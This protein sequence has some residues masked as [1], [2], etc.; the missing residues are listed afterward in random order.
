LRVR[1]PGLP[2]LVLLILLVFSWNLANLGFSTTANASTPSY[3]SQSCLASS[4]YVYCVQ[5]ENTYYAPLSSS[6]IGPWKTS[7]S[8]PLD[9]GTCYASG[10]AVYCLDG[11]DGGVESN[12]VYYAIINS[13]GFGKWTKTTSYPVAES[14]GG[15]SCFASTAFIY[16]LGGNSTVLG[17][18]PKGSPPGTNGSALSYYAS[19]TSSGVGT[20]Q[21]TSEYPLAVLYGSGPYTTNGTG[22]ICVGSLGYAYCIAGAYCYNTIAGPGCVS[23]RYAYYAAMGNGIQSPVVNGTGCPPPGLNCPNNWAKTTNYPDLG[24]SFDNS[25]TDVA[26]LSCSTYSSYIYCVGG[27]YYDD[28]NSTYYATVSSSGIGNW[29]KTTSYPID[30][31]EATCVTYSGYIYCIDGIT[32]HETAN[33]ISPPTT[34]GTTYYAPISSSGIGSWVA[35]NDFGAGQTSS[36]TSSSSMTSSSTTAAT[37]TTSI[38]ETVTATETGGQQVPLGISTNSPT[39]VITGAQISQGTTTV[40]GTTEQTFTVSFSATAQSGSSA[41]TTVTVPK[42]AVPGGLTPMVSIDGSAAPG[43]SYNQDANN[44]Y[45][46]FATH[47]STHTVT[48]EFAPPSSSTSSSTSSSVGG[49]PEFPAQ[50]GFTLL[51]TVV[52]VISYLFARRGL[53]VGKP[54]PV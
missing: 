50:L 46:T 5:G 17:G 13:S 1:G 35:T 39:L 54:V 24:S 14:L 25:Y 15:P 42:S 19:V 21:N 48:I 12:S 37:A 34:I 36:T 51:A 38:T 4:G 45:V 20:W 16:C 18:A 8:Y 2:A 27:G 33:S 11:R 6:G 49:I 31:Y 40:S 32:L 44:Y 28:T 53:R 3:I 43:Q 41:A 47:F 23:G 30:V 26:N 9:A 7:T 10:S 29:T 22:P 52:I